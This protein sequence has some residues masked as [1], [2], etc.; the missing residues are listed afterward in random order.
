MKVRDNQNLYDIAIQY[1]GSSEAA[2]DIAYLNGI[3]VTDSLTVGQELELPPVVS[4][5]I[6]DYYANKSL[7]PATSLT[8]TQQNEALAEGIDFWAVE[9]EFI[10]S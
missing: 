4:K 1:C 5:S 9:T 8:E 2:Y 10:I 6:V 7:T 3:S